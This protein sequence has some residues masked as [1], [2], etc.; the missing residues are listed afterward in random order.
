VDARR[1]AV[2]LAQPGPH[3]QAD[4]GEEPRLFL[5]HLLPPLPEPVEDYFNEE[6]QAFIEFEEKMTGRGWAKTF[7]QRNSHDPES[8]WYERAMVAQAGGNE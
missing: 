4:V 6:V 2:E 3:Q 8:D 7:C 5:C 1:P